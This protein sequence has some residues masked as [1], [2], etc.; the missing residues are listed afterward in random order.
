MNTVAPPPISSEINKARASNADCFKSLFD[1]MD[2]GVTMKSE[3]PYDQRK[4]KIVVVNRGVGISSISISDNRTEGFS[5]INE[6]GDNS[7]YCW[8]CRNNILHEDDGEQSKFGYGLKCGSA[9]IGHKLD[10]LTKSGNKYDLKQCDWDAMSAANSGAG[11]YDPKCTPCNSNYFRKEHP[12]SEGTT[13]KLSELRSEQII[14]FTH[15]EF[16]S[17]L[18]AKISRTYAEYIRDGIHIYVNDEVVPAINDP[19]VYSKQKKFVWCNYVYERDNKLNVVSCKKKTKK[20]GQIYRHDGINKNETVLNTYDWYDPKYLLDNA[21]LSSTNLKDDRGL[22]EI[23]QECKSWGLPNGTVQISRGKRVYGYRDY[24]ERRNDGYQNYTWHSLKY[25]SKKLDDLLGVTYTK[26]IDGRAPDNVLN[27][28]I[29]YAHSQNEKE[30][31]S[32]KIAGYVEKPTNN[33]T[34]IHPV[35]TKTPCVKPVPN[36]KPINNKLVND[37]T[38]VVKPT[39]TKFAPNIKLVDE[40][41]I[42]PVDTETPRVK[43]AL[44]TK[45]VDESIIQPVDTETPCVKPVPNIKPINNKPLNDPT[46]VVKP[47]NTKS[48]PNNKPINDPTVVVKPTNTKPV[49]EQVIR[50]VDDQMVENKQKVAYGPAAYIGWYK[51][52]NGGLGL[53]GPDERLEAKYGYTAQRPKKRASGGDYKQDFDMR[54]IKNVTENV[55][56]ELGKKIEGVEGV[57]VGI[58]EHFTVPRNKWND[59]E[60]I[61][62]EITSRVKRNP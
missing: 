20:K 29:K 36:I 42:Q 2:G 46:L 54:L 44:N 45:P 60:D 55:E 15:T 38:V 48:A 19:M 21:E 59:I 23:S 27:E 6:T 12:F 35:D 39:N 49:D 5:N 8:G 41:I 34:V 50:P 9:N 14:K 10:I 13:I 62:W 4:V 52:S 16:I 40:S 26:S 31:T 25:N 28:A 18:I 7:P 32:K 11:T 57:K 17:K 58:G 56:N 53:F 43:L 30:F 47:T 51:N 37:P 61:F 33:P 22:A 1:I 3:L 24:K